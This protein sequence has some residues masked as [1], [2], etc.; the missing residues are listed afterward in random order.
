MNTQTRTISTT[1]HF[2]LEHEG[3]PT[4]TVFRELV[5]DED[6][7]GSWLVYTVEP[8]SVGDAGETMASA[9]VRVK[10]E[11]SVRLLADLFSM[12][13]GPAVFGSQSQRTETTH[14]NQ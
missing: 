13:A 11:A 10:D 5:A 7:D 9:S 8:S 4:V 6:S 12:L 3:R 1:A 14:D 2:T